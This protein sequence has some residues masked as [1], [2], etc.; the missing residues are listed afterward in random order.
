[1][2]AIIQ[3]NPLEKLSQEPL[4]TEKIRV[5]WSFLELRATWR[6]ACCMDRLW[7]AWRR[8]YSV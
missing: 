3:A 7:N 6:N 8:F 5:S 4:P 2:S 1:M